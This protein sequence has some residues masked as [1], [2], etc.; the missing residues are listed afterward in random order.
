MPRRS[1]LDPAASARLVNARSPHDRAPCRR[2]HSSDCKKV[3]L[4]HRCGLRSTLQQDEFAID[5]QELGDAPALL[6]GVRS[7]QRLVD[8]RKPLGSL[9]VTTEG[10]RNLGENWSVECK[11][12]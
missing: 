12:A 7:R 8:D 6:V 1:D 9:T 3:L 5:A 10:V 4:G 11:R 2:A